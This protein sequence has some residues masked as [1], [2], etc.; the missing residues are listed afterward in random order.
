[1]KPCTCREQKKHYSVGE[2]VQ[3][4]IGKNKY[5]NGIVTHIDKRSDTIIKNKRCTLKETVIVHYNT[6]KLDLKRRFM[7]ESLFY[8][9]KTSCPNV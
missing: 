1:M 2:L 6:G 7:P 3:I 4:L 5:I 9:N 8:L